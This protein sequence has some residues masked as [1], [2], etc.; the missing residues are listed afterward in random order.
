MSAIS[1]TKSFSETGYRFLIGKILSGDLLPGEEINRRAIAD[2]LKMSLAPVN[3]AVAQLENEGFLEILPRK[4]TRVRIVRP[5]EV[6]AL[7]ILREAIECQAARLYCGKVIA[8]R[9]PALTK[10]ARAVDASKPGSLENEQAESNFHGALVALVGVP[11][12]TAEFQKVMRRRLFCKINAVLPY[13]TQPPLDSHQQL[14]KKLQVRDPDKA[15]AAMRHHLER[16]RK[17]VLKP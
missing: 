11:L 7:L 3:E 4:Q 2:E 12:L 13:S 15:E 6:R 5:E 9:L 1:T 17:A 8:A 10:L 14:L 16:G